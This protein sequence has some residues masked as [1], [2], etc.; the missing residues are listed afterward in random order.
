MRPFWSRR[1]AEV[2]KQLPWLDETTSHSITNETTQK[3]VFRTRKIKLNPTKEQKL[4]LNAYADG[5]RYTYNA[6]IDA[7]NTRTNAAN[8]IQ[9]QNAFV[10]LKRQHDG[11]YNSF[12]D[13]RRWLLRTPQAI[14]QQAVFEA[15]DKFKTAFTNL[16]NNNIDH[17]KMKFKTKKHQRQHGYSLGIGKHLRYKKNVL[18]ILPRSIGSMRF[19]GKMPFEGVPDAEC[20]IHRDPYGDFWLLVPLKK[21]SPSSSSGPVVAIDPGVRTPFA[22]FATDGTTTTLGEDM[23][24]R[25]NVIRVKISLNDRRLSKATTSDLRKRCREHRL[26]LYRQHQRVRDAYH[27]RII[28]DITNGAGGILL[29]PFETQKM[30]KTLKAKTN[31]SMLGISHF[32]F[33]RRMMNRCEEKSLLYAEPTEEYTSKTCGSCGRINYLLGSK[34]TFECFCGSMC[35][36]DT[37]AARN[38]LLKW[39]ST[40]ETGARVLETFPVSRSISTSS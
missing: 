18:T 36:R 15:A 38:I 9:L 3:N 10:S 5:T 24:D 33:R 4:K 16:N 1:C 27:W 21:T 20:R 2:S 34:K 8:R 32:T 11:S 22:C 26:R 29:P 14:R 35:D 7:V 13:K 30:S 28:N 25:L 39:L 40:T 19:F 37:H 23:N 6:A 12:F 31:R 17:F